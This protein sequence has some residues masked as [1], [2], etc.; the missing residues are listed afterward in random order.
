LEHL[1]GMIKLMLHQ[2]LVEIQK[3]FMV[4]VLLI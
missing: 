3:S 1:N 2:Q 4:T